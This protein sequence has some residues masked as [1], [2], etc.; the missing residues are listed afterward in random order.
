[1]RWRVVPATAVS[2]WS[3]R[4]IGGLCPTRPGGRRQPRVSV[5]SGRPAWLPS[6]ASMGRDDHTRLPPHPGAEALPGGA[7]G[8]RGFR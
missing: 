4:R 2:V 3:S 1:M 6:V 8:G 7:A 5:A